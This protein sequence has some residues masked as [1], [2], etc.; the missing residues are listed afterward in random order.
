MTKNEVIILGSFCRVMF[1][2]SILEYRFG[3]RS[4]CGGCFAGRCYLIY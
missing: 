4:C 1:G 3:F 2:L